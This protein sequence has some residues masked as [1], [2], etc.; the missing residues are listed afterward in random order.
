MNVNLVNISMLTMLAPVFNTELCVAQDSRPNVI[1]ILCDDM[2]YSDIG[3]YGG[4]INTPNLDSLASNG[5]RF[6]QFYNAGRSCPSRASLLTG[7]YPHQ[8]G[9]G[10]MTHKVYQG[11]V[12]QGFLNEKCITLAELMR[13][14]GYSTGISG[15]WHV[16]TENEAWPYNRGFDEVFAIHNWVDSY[17]RVLED[18]EIYKDSSIYMGE[19]PKDVILKTKDGKDWYTTDVFTDKAID[20]IER[21]SRDEKPFFLYTAYNAPHWPL[22][23][24]D[25]I[26]NKYLGKYSEGWKNLI[27]EKTERMKKMGIIPYS[28]NIGWQEMVDWETLSE[29]DK[30]NTEFRRA[31]YAAQ[32]EI[33]DYNVGRIIQSLKENNVYDNTVIIFLSDN[34]CSA[35]PETENFGYSWKEN[36]ISNYQEWKRN[37]GREGSS[38]G[39]MW[40]IASNAPFRKYKKFIHEGG[41]STP[42]ILSYPKYK[43]QNG[44]LVRTP[45][46]L[47]DIMA[48]CVDIANTVYPDKYKGRSILP[49]D[50]RSIFPALLG[51]QLTEHKQ[52][53]WEHEGHAGI[54]MGKWKL[55]TENINKNNWELYDM[56]KDRT[57]TIDLSTN[58]PQIKEQLK[59]EWDNWANKVGVFPKNKIIRSK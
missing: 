48:T 2:G 23:A 13:D 47:P 29:D 52:I 49:S 27:I 16:G 35:E 37:S 45:S 32:V 34:G 22:E 50:G 39:V 55:V 17:Y 4:E 18:C 33:L 12:Y 41:I 6:T 24:H 19:T 38:Q 15:K 25:S 59:K 31:I 46:F 1:L 26:V 11:P 42:L 7:L 51:E 54:R 44:S 5:I 40:S 8:A 21:H 10:H 58:Y 57:E 9:I 3:C 30:L 53:C 20:F 28:T 56:D 36:R 43:K 14:A